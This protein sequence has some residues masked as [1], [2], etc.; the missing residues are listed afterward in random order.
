MATDGTS[1]R[2]RWALYAALFVLYL[3]HNDLWLWDDARLIAS[4]PVGL[5]YHVVYSLVVSVA[6]ALLVGLAW[7][8][9]DV[10]EDRQE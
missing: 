1:R 9:M 10:S 4:L 7:P 2:R 5:L 6:L 3:L 8:E